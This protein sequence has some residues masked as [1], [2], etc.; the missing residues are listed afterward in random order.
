MREFVLFGLG[1]SEP[2][3]TVVNTSEVEG[4]EWNRHLFSRR[5]KFARF[6]SS[7]KNNSS[8]TTPG[9]SLVNE[10]DIGCTIMCNY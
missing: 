8:S 5:S 10:L 4:D 7:V 1:S 6:S 9:V 3:K 2:V